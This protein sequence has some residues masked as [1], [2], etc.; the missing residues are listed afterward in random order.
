[1]KRI[2]AIIVF[3]L[4]A[5]LCLAAQA[6]PTDTRV[7][8]SMDV[9]GTITVSPRG[10]VIGYKLDRPDRLPAYVVEMLNRA[11]PAWRF[12]PNL[13]NGHP[14]IARAAMHIRLVAKPQPNGKYA[15][16]IDQTTF[17][18]R[19]AKDATQIQYKDHGNKPPSYP[20]DASRYGVN[21]NVYLIAD[22][23]RQE[24]VTKAAVT[25][26]DLRTR[27]SPNTMERWRRD[28]ASS[29]L[30]AVRQWQ[31]RVPSEGIF[32]GMDHWIV[33][34]PIDYQMIHNR[35]TKANAHYGKWEVYIPGTYHT[36]AWAQDKKTSAHDR[37]PAGA[38]L[39]IAG[40]GLHRITKPG[41]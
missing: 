5:S 40:S 41:S 16:S 18:S 10:N 35:D 36:V 12:Y 20:L 9:H 8:A 24:L 11:I 23:N 3:A 21:A 14:F 32:A 15:V 30:R 38:T 29:A 1:M 6:S 27:G 37:P 4:L 7:Q 28:F 31:F 17:G 39:Q 19:H 13:R 33:Q 26:V 34:I 25:E 22:I 2:V